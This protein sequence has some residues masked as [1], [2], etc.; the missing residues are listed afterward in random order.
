MINEDE[1]DHYLIKSKLSHIG[2]RHSN[3]GELYNYLHRI[4]SKLISIDFID[5]MEVIIRNET[6]DYILDDFI[7]EVKTPPK[8]Y[9]INISNLLNHGGNRYDNYKRAIDKI[10]NCT[11]IND[12][13]RMIMI[14]PINREMSNNIVSYHP[15]INSDFV[16]SYKGRNEIR[17]I[18]NRWQ[19]WN[20]I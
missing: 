12:N 3:E 13:I 20:M 18:K 2:F 16:C 15:M 6:I 8:F 5:N 4:E 14:S 10:R 19:Q 17:I 11:L 1:L 9:V 7:S